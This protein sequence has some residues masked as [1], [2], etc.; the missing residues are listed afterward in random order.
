MRDRTELL[1]PGGQAALVLAVRAAMGG[2][3][4]LIL[5]L[6]GGGVIDT[7]AVDDAVDAVL[8]VGSAPP[9]CAALRAAI[10]RPSAGYARVWVEIMG[11]QQCGIVGESQPVLSMI[12]PMSFTRTR[13]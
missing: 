2:A 10:T 6:M 11:S 9:A 5:A 4:P 12:D 7:S 1:L 8:W 13:M 3:K